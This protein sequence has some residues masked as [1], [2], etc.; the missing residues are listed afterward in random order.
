MLEQWT[1]NLDRPDRPN[2]PMSVRLYVKTGDDPLPVIL[3]SHDAALHP[4][5]YERLLI[6]W[7]SAGYMVIAPT[8]LDHDMQSSDPKEMWLSRLDDSILAL[9]FLKDA[10]RA[11]LST[12]AVAGHASG[13]LVAHALAGAITYD[14]AGE[15]V[16]AGDNRVGAVIAL[17]PKAEQDG[18]T[19]PNSWDDITAPLFTQTY[20]KIKDE[21]STDSWSDMLISHRNAASRC[22]DLIILDDIEKSLQVDA[23]DPSTIESTNFEALANLNKY[24]IDFLNKHLR[25]GPQG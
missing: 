8:H 2:D 3:F 12:I 1:V 7:A 23:T 18:F 9:N 24:V 16:Q 20:S 14:M 19:D 10:A 15:I 17:C 21:I 13:A 25:T 6:P 5:N 22:K 4:D 11:D